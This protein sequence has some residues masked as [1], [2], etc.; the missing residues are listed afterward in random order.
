MTIFWDYLV[1][2]MLFVAAL[3]QIAVIRD[4]TI[5]VTRAAASSR[6]ILSAGLL[7]LCVRFAY[8]IYD[9]GRLELPLHSLLSIGGIALGLIGLELPRFAPFHFMDT[10][11]GADESDLPQDRRHTERRHDR[12]NSTVHLNNER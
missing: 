8:V 7:G 2:A 4:H 6:W 9:H 1:T 11:P 10:R 3:L 12:R 5:Y